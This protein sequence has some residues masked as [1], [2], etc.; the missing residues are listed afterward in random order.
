M[1][2]LQFTWFPA[3]SGKSLTVVAAKA[4][5]EP[6]AAVDEANAALEDVLKS[7]QESV[8][9]ST[10]SP[11]RRRSKQFEIQTEPGL[12]FSVCLCGCLLLDSGCSSGSW[13]SVAQL[14]V[15]LQWEKTD[16]KPAI[17]TLVVAGLITLWASFALVN[18]S[19]MVY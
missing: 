8:S 3:G 4:T 12:R 14:C 9:F 11:A 16:D 18:V 2:N 15:C 7:V 6:E 17:A 10:C 5:N 19:D 1:L 13:T